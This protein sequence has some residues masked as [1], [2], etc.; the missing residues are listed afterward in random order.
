MRSEPD[1]QAKLRRLGLYPVSSVPGPGT[2]TADQTLASYEV[3]PRAPQPD[4]RLRWE[5]GHIP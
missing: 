5:L 4:L 3:S 1:L 2:P